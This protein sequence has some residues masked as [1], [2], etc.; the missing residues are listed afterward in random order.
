MSGMVAVIEGEKC[1]I[2]GKDHT[3]EESEPTKIDAGA[4]AGNWFS[5]KGRPTQAPI[6]FLDKR[7]DPPQVKVEHFTHGKTVPP[8]RSCEVIVPLLICDDGKDA[9]SHKT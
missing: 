7:S 9:C 8:C 3:F 1:P 5:S 6:Q 2:C 4:L